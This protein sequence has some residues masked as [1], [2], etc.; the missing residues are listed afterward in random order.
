MTAGDLSLTATLSLVAGSEAYELRR[1]RSESIHSSSSLTLGKV[2]INFYLY[3]CI[4]HLYIYMCVCAKIVTYRDIETNRG[5]AE[6]EIIYAEIS[7][8]QCAPVFNLLY[9]LTIGAR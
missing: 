5:S 1:G 4:V 8:A 7:H 3:K 6:Q 2:I 9:I